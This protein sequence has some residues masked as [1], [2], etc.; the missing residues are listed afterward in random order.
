MDQCLLTDTGRRILFKNLQN[1]ENK[2][3]LF[4]PDNVN[5]DEIVTLD[6]SDVVDK[7][8]IREKA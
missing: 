8:I 7:A 2:K 6:Q 4:Y 1:K 5:F 3:A